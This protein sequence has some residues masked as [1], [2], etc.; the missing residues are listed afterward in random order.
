VSAGRQLNH[1]RLQ[2]MMA[3]GQL[4]GPRKGL[5]TSYDPDNYL[6]KVSIQPEDFET[7]WLPITTLMA[8]DGFGA[9]FGPSQ[10]DQAAVVFELN[11][12]EAGFCIGFC[13]SDVDQPPTVQSGEMHLIAKQGQFVKLLQ[14][15]S[16]DAAADANTTLTLSPGGAI[17][18]KG[19]WTHTGD[20]T[21][22]GTV[23]GNTDVLGAGVS[24]K[25]HKHPVPGVQTGGSTVESNTP[26]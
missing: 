2:A 5:V 6:V 1:M 18:T 15:G 22:S 14:D 17:S 21:A 8:G 11:N 19:T 24:V 7:G 25:G 12:R 4:T 3:A 10:G 16:V 9:Y 26:G 20:F 23:R 13:G